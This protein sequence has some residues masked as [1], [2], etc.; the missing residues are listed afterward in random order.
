MRTLKVPPRILQFTPLPTLQAIPTTHKNTRLRPNCISRSPQVGNKLQQA[1]NEYYAKKRGVQGTAYSDRSLGERSEDLNPRQR[2]RKD[3]F[4]DF[5]KFTAPRLQ[6]KSIVM[7]QALLRGAYVRKKV[8]PQIVQFHA[9]SVRTVD[10]MVDHYIEDVFIPDLLLELLAKNKVYENFDLYSEENRVLYEVRAS[11]MEKVI[12]DMVKET[13]KTS[14]DNIVNRYLN[15]RYREKDADER[16]PLAMV[17]KSIMDGVMKKQAKDIASNAV[18][19][20][21]LDYLIQAQFYSLFNRVWLPREVEHT[22]VDTIEDFAV[23][24][25][26][27]GTIDK[28]IRQEA[29]RIADDAL[30]SEKA[31]QDTEILENAFMEYLDRCI[32]ESCTNNLAIMYEEEEGR[33]HVKEQQEKALRDHARQK[34]NKVKEENR[35]LDKELALTKDDL[36]QKRKLVKDRQGFVNEIQ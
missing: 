35:E 1:Q 30:E 34:A 10:A 20:L 6:Y 15:K 25:V 24:E 23:E 9:A 27:K 31:R 19:E 33:I 17:V 14:T 12:R 29:P 13:V 7:I 4:E 22:I 2:R 11:I 28:I 32:L 18:H 16:D 5:I 21:S 36:E 8:F 26:I 3:R